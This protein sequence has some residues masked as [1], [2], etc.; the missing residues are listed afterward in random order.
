[1]RSH[2]LVSQIYIYRKRKKTCKTLADAVCCEFNDKLK[3]WP[4]IIQSDG[5]MMKGYMQKDS[6]DN[7]KSMLM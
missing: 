2:K 3:G 6:G 5:K 7:I 1:M 4:K